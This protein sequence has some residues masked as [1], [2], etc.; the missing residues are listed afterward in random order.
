MRKFRVSLIVN[1]FLYNYSVAASLTVL[2]LSANFCSIID[3]Q[4]FV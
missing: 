1:E 4:R 3:G 2:D